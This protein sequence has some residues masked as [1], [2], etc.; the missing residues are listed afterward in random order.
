VRRDHADV[1]AELRR[2]VK[3]V[4][5]A[6]ALQRD[7]LDSLMATDRVWTASA[8]QRD[9]LDHPLVGLIARSLIWCS[10]PQVGLPEQMSDGTWGLRS[11]EGVVVPTAA[12]DTIALWH[13]LGRPLAEVARWREHLTDAEIRQPFKQA[14]R[15]IYLLT[16]AEEQTATY[17]NRFAAHILRY[18]PAVGLM[19]TRG[20]RSPALGEWDSGYAGDATRWFGDLRASFFVQTVDQGEYE[21]EFCAT[22]QVRFERRQAGWG[23]EVVPVVEV[24]PR[25]FSEAMRDVDLFVGVASIGADPQWLDNARH[26]HRDYWEEF[27]FGE[28]S[29]SAAVRRE[30][31]EQII[32]RTKLAGRARVEGRFLVVDGRLRT[33]KIHLGSGNI[34]MSPNDAYLCIVPKPMR[35]SSTV[36]LPFEED[37][38]LSVILSKAF[39]LA[40]DDTI[41]DRE[42]LDQLLFARDRP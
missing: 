39:L 10:G 37:G 33:Y 31:V 30:A 3:D 42:I 2:T 27:S 17:S 9:Y 13:P 26:R 34:L 40:E 19:R 18:R 35:P 21:T 7:R 4:R 29:S 12:E 20:W 22:D 14:F 28:L 16:P 23:L 25:A 11:V 1:V 38:R 8:W 32:G 36:Y 6:L 15:E 41:T 5:K 24:D